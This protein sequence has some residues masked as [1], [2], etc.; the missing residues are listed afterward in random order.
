MQMCFMQ[1]ASVVCA[2]GGPY[3]QSSESSLLGKEA[4]TFYHL[5]N[6]SQV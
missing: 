2:N 6:A 4:Y 1:Y 5:K 3:L